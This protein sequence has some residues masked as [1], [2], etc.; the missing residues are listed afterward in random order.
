ME[1]PATMLVNAHEE[2]AM[3]FNIKT[4]AVTSAILC[5]LVMLLVG[6]ANLIC[7]SYGLQ[8]LQTMSSVWPG[9]HAT[10]SVADFILGI[11]YGAVDGLI[12]GAAFAWL[13]NW[14]HDQFAKHGV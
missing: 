9:Y 1:I 12:Y 5:G 8:F 3:K 7:G 14:L 10:R 4:L 13:Y 6:L 11:L 2:G